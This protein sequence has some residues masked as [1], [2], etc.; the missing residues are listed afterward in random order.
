MQF[1]ARISSDGKK[2]KLTFREGQK[3]QYDAFI[4]TIPDGDVVL[5]V[6]ERRPTRSVRA[7]RRWWGRIVRTIQ[8]VWN[9]GRDIPLSEGQ[10][11]TILVRVFA[12]EIETPLGFVPVETHT[13]PSDVFALFQDK[14]EGH[15][16]AEGIS[17]PDEY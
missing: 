11:H 7:N 1:S 12:G 5:T 15:F 9:V 8:G 2:K 16:A 3:A 14:V 4:G 10:V 17:F 13:M 6:E